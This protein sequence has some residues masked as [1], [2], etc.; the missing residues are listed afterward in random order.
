MKLVKL[1]AAAGGNEFL[2]LFSVPTLHA[3]HD[4]DRL[5]FIAACIQQIV[6]DFLFR[7]HHC[8]QPFFE[9]LQEL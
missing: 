7:R 9:F 2:G 8:F 5:G 4:V 1:L 3:M 6:P